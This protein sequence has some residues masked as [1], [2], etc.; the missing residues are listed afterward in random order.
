MENSTN[1]DKAKIIKTAAMFYREGQWDNALAEHGKILALDKND[2]DS[3][4]AVGDIYSKKKS[5]QLAFE[6]YFKAAPAYL[7]Q[8]QPDKAVLIYQKITRMDLS[9][10]SADVRMNMSFYQSYVDIDDILKDKRYEIAIAPLGKLLKLRPQDP[11]GLALLK[12]LSDQV[13]KITPSIQRYQQLSETFTKNGLLDKAGDMLK[14]I[15]DMDPQNMSARLDLVQM[16]LKQGST[17]EAKKEYLQLAEEALAK[18]DLNGAYEFAQ[19]AIE[20]KSLEGGYLL[21]VIHFKKK[22]YSEAQTEFEKLLRIKV[23]HLGGLTHLA[24]TFAVLGQPEKAKETFQKALKVDENNIQVQEAWVEF[25]LQGKDQ[26]LAIPHLT[27][28]LDKAVEANHAE[29]T[30]KF[31][32]ML[33]ELRPDLVSSRIKLIK[34]LQASGDLQS[35]ADALRGLAMIYEHEGQLTDAAQCLE[36][37]NELVPSAGVSKKDSADIQP[38]ATMPPASPSSN[39][40]ELMVDIPHHSDPDDVFLFEG[41]TEEDSIPSPP[42]PAPQPAKIDVM[43]F[44]TE[45]DA[46][47]S[48]P[49]PPPSQPSLSD[50]VEAKMTTANMCVQQGLLKAAIE[51][52]QQILE[53]KPGL[54]E[55]RKKLYEVN[56]LYLKKWV[57][58]KK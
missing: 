2:P 5:F 21:G 49:P 32:K 56:A 44:L 13:D 29:R 9:K 18:D 50:D 26:D 58:S 15:S 25:C 55:V 52:Y 35:T 40:I 47:A 54:V 27:V 20:L 19:K 43:R 45:E 4:A 12:N 57:D 17:G 7:T 6:F 8:G 37:A 28:L 51:I 48:S 46:V 39:V 30:I 10:L 38:T 3:L 34:G 1:P 33:I 31:S 23:N 22:K 14:K 11:M 36:K 24:K 42:P 16:R 53:T 41:K